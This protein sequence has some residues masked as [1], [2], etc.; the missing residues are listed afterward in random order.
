MSKKAKNPKKKNR[1]FLFIIVVLSI[2]LFYNV[3]ALIHEIDYRHGY[4]NELSDFDMAMRNGDY[5]GLEEM[6]GR[7]LG[8]DY[9]TIHDCSSYEAMGTYYRACVLAKAYADTGNKEKADAYRELAEQCYDKFEHYSQKKHA[10]K[11]AEK[12]LED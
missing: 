5:A 3:L 11:L 1:F 12:Y 2:A 9:R 4:G 8:M 7:N 6:A 10:D